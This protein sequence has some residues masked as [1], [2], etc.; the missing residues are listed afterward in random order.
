MTLRIIS[1]SDQRTKYSSEKQPFG[2]KT[3]RNK[4][5]SEFK[6]F[7]EMRR[8]NIELSPCY[9]GYCSLFA[10]TCSWKPD[11]L[12]DE[13]YH[14]WLFCFQ[15][16]II[17]L[18]Q[19]LC[20]LHF[21][22][23][24]FV[25]LIFLKS[26]VFLWYNFRRMFPT[27]RVSLSGLRS[28]SR[29]VVMMDII[30]KDNKRYRYAYHRSSWLVAG[31]ADPPLPPRLYVHPDSPFTGEQLHKQMVS[32][33]KVK[34]TNNELDQ[35]GHVSNISEGYFS[36]HFFLYVSKLT[37]W[38]IIFHLKLISNRVG[39]YSTLYGNILAWVLVLIIIPGGRKLY[40]VTFLLRAFLTVFSKIYKFCREK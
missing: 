6:P 39:S 8:R 24:N 15:K 3:F 21:L 34:L 40:C 37:L 17:V 35:Q 9:L 4:N 32:F 10:S 25:C 23:L 29:Y 27:V 38:I 13:L 19:F 16:V 28:D 11:E 18:R 26:H 12:G 1:L 33:E 30:P 14:M 20:F 5:R 22:L 31:K 7:G 36:F 2:I